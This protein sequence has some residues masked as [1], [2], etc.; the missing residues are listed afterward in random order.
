MGRL[1]YSSRRTCQTQC[2]RLVR[3]FYRRV[4]ARD[5]HVTTQ[6]GTMSNF[7]DV[8]EDGQEIDVRGPT[9]EIEYLGKGA[10]NIE[11]KTHH[12]SKV[13]ALCLY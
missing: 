8:L 4:S 12:F 6:G 13:S 1:T 11:G 10:F 5:L 7:L 2:S 3:S 9:G